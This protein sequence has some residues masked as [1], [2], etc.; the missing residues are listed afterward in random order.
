VPVHVAHDVGG[1]EI[2]MHYIMAVGL[3]ERLHDF[4]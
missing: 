4:I 1:L 3:V 2:A